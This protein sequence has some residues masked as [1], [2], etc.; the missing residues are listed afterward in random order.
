M[1]MFPLLACSTYLSSSQKHLKLGLLLAQ[2]DNH[3][4]KRD[5]DEENQA[6]R[7]HTEEPNF[8]C[9]QASIPT[10]FSM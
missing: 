1:V 10:M 4:N 2:L 7:F 5:L 6:T 3:N 9:K 8:L